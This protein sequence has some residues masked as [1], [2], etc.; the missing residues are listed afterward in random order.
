MWTICIV[1]AKDYDLVGAF[2]KSNGGYF[3]LHRRRR[4]RFLLIFDWIFMKS[5]SFHFGQS[6]TTTTKQKMKKF[7]DFLITLKGTIQ[8][9]M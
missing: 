4:R 1:Y 9:P 6:Q 5:S 3:H 2:T 8:R 7:A